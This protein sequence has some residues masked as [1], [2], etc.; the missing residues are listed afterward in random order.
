MDKYKIDGHKLNYHL[1]RVNDWL[2]QRT[3]YPIYVEISPAGACNHRCNFCAV[4][5]IGYQNRF[6]DSE[7][8]M[9]RLVEMGQLGVRSVMF[10]GEGEPLLHNDLP[11]IIQ[12]TREIG[13]DVA[14]TTNAIPL[15]EKWAREALGSIT[16]IKVSI[17]AGTPQTYARIHGTREQDF[18]LAI[19]NLTVAAKIRKEMGWE[20]TLGSQML[21]LP[22][23][24]DE[25]VTL[26]QIIKETGCD[27]LV[28]KPYSQHR[29]SITRIY[30]AIDYGRFRDLNQELE[31]F[32]DESFSVV[33]RENTMTKLNQIQP[34]S[35]CQATPYFWAYVMADG[36]VYGCSAYLQDSRFNYGN[37]MEKSFQEIWLGETRSK[38]IDYVENELNIKDCRVNCRMDEANRYLWDLKHP[39]EH[40][41]F[42]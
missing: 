36:S 13:I 8:L 6:L 4:D 29:S 11:A 41:N 22:D 17:N 32:N 10:A 20:C 25:V 31:R 27:Y 24:F 12:K 30:E 26:A 15:T 37:I 1:S 39:V 34:Y 18:N 33:L 14:V 3:V 42:I 5:Y 19:N 23:N 21:L 9:A 35:R 16:W 40:V 2:E 38:N 28:I 7:I